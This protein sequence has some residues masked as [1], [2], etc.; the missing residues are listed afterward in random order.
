MWH[1]SALSVPVLFMLFKPPNSLSLSLFF[2]CRNQ[3]NKQLRS[4]P[5]SSSHGAA[6]LGFESWRFGC[7]TH[8]ISPVA[9]AAAA[10][11][12]ATLE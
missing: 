11:A 8:S 10:A 1:V 3:G 5:R 6:G 4:F 12:A 2:G 7:R 9:A